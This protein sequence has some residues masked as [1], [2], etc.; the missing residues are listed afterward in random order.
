MSFQEYADTKQPRLR[1]GR[2]SKPALAGMIV[3]GVLCIAFIAFSL[4]STPVGFEIDKAEASVEEVAASEEAPSPAEVYVHVAGCVARPGIC[5]LNAQARV[6]EAIEA[7]GGF[8]EDAATESVNLA[9]VVEDGEQ[10]VV[11]SASA[12]SEDAQAQA[13]SQASGVAVQ[14][15]SSAGRVNINTATESELQTISGIGPSKAAKIIAYRESNGSFKTVDDLTNVS[16]IG[17]KTLESIRDQIC[18]G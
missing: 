1:F 18:V 15:A 16:G 8:T 6:A 7:V 9:R 3:L 11:A 14:S 2:L 4:S 12:A 10:I 13:P 17:Q 5:K